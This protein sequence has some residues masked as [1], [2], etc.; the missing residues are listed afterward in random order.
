MQYR[1]LFSL[2]LFAGAVLL[3]GCSRNHEAIG[4]DATPTSPAAI[5][6]TPA[7]P[8]KPTGS[9]AVT[10][11]TA[12]PTEIAGTT[13]PTATP[14]PTMTPTPSPSPTPIPTVPPAPAAINT[15]TADNTFLVNRDNPL[16]DG[17]A[18]SDL[19]VPDIP[20]SFTSKTADK[21]KLR[22]VAAKALEELYQTAL[23]EEGLKITG[24][25]GYRS[26]DRQ[27]DIYA[28]NLISKGIRHTN[29]Y[30][31]APGRS[32][33]QTGLAID[34][35]CAS[36]N[37]SLINSFATTPEGIWLKENSWRFGFILRYPKDKEDITG[38][39]YEPWHI[40]YVGVPLAYYLYTNNLTLEE[41]Y[42]TNCSY[43]KN[44][45]AS[46]SLIDTST[47][48]F[49]ALYAKVKNGFLLTAADGSPLLSPVSGYPY[50]ATPIRDAGGT[51]LMN[52]SVPYYNEPVLRADGSLM[53]DE[54]DAVV[55]KKPY[56][57]SNGNLWLTYDGSPVYL[58]PLTNA[59]GSL[60]TD[61][62]GA[63]LYT[64]AVRDGAGLEFIT[65]DGGIL[66]KLPIRLNGELTYLAD[67]SVA[68]YEPIL[69]EDGSFIIRANGYPLF[70]ADYYESLPPVQ[71]PETEVTPED[72]VLPEG[73]ENPETPETPAGEAP[74]SDPDSEFGI[75]G[76]P[77]G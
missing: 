55:F 2:L 74:A 21:R 18:P 49:Y 54:Q 44:Y 46:Q 26:Y 76:Y 64:D 29:S 8:T 25:S 27:Y 28:T 62:D 45:L 7:Q 71:E 20:F 19:V 38:Y 39:A 68:F 33:H 15:N 16:P 11:P 42:G 9:A 70:P 50:L 47:E 69:W 23:S 3:S 13:V 30:S 66:P 48:R 37:Y 41:Y 52:G 53:T 40:R 22:P 60:A 51:V 12:A 4:A 61:A 63:V 1:K 57:D 14:M 43:S 32:E 59:D 67:G 5:I 6:T 24:V 10:E 34:V 36:I 31:A 65:E 56:F 72:P 73:P 17:Y 58:E 35:S 77:V 75:P